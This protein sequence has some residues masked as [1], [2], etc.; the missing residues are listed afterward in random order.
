MSV[1]RDLKYN[2]HGEYIVF[3]KNKI[4][5][6][7]TNIINCKATVTDNYLRYISDKAKISQ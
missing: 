2:V 7:N 4:M 3:I 1:W 6:S 5:A